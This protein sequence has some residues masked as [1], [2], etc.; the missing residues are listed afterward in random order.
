MRSPFASAYFASRSGAARNHVRT[1][2][3]GYFDK[4]GRAADPRA[5][6]A[7]QRWN[8]DLSTHRSRKLDA[9]LLDWADLVLVMD[10]ANLEAVRNHYPAARDKTYLLGSL[11]VADH[12]TDVEIPDPYTG[13]DESVV[14]AYGRIAGAID[15]LMVHVSSGSPP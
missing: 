5:V 3:A 1:A 7:G 11:E 2:S 10:L 9:T 14:M 15:R 8:I 13:S 4:T 6:A 12:K